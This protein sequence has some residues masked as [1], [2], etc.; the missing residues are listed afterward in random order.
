MDC[1]VRVDPVTKVEYGETLKSWKHE[2]RVGESREPRKLI[3]FSKREVK[4]GKSREL[5]V[6]GCWLLSSD[7]VDCLFEV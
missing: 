4:A 3:I 5:C 6:E 7:N 2:G 1:C